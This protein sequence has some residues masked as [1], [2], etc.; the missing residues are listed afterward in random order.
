MALTG[1]LPS[2]GDHP[3]AKPVYDLD[4]VSL[5]TVISGLNNGKDMMGNAL[6][7]KTDFSRVLWLI[8]ELIM[9]HPTIYR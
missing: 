7:G 1:D 4:S 3:Q 8:P 2:S 5:L 9:K 6:Q